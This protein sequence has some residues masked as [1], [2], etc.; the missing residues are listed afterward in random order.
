MSDKVAHSRLLY[1]PDFYGM[2]NKTKKWIES[3]LSHRSQQVSVGG[4]KSK[5]AEVTSGVPH[6]TVLGP[7]LFLCSINDLPESILSSDAK[8]FADDSLLFNVIENDKDKELLQRDLSALELWEE[9][10]HMSFNPT[11]CVVLRISKKKKTAR[12]IH[13]QLHGRTLEVVNASKYLGVTLR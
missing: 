4:V 10:W 6:G 11:K 7:L 5:T 12:Q 8:L 9:A 1:K 13:Y 3:F 2:R